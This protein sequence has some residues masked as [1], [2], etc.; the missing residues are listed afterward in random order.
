MQIIPSS[1][2]ERKNHEPPNTQYRFQ[3]M[4]ASDRSHGYL[5]YK[6]KIIRDIGTLQCCNFL[7]MQ[8]SSTRGSNRA[9]QRTA[10]SYVFSVTTMHCL[11]RQ[12][13]ST[14]LPANVRDKRALR[15]VGLQLN[16]RGMH[17]PPPITWYNE[18]QGRELVFVPGSTNASGALILDVSD[19]LLSPRGPYQ[20]RSKPSPSRTAETSWRVA[21][22]VKTSVEGG[23]GVMYKKLSYRG[24]HSVEELTRS[25]ATSEG[26]QTLVG[27]T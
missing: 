12:T 11:H 9:E 21:N 23:C 18:R 24:W 10:Q 4:C 7:Y 6:G 22:I 17:R 3:K 1:F 14:K 26:F 5:D 8:T 13:S 25:C 27:Y 15:Q 16:S 20:A 19:A 2:K